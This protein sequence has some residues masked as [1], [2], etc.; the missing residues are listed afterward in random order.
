MRLFRPL[1][2]LHGLD[3][4]QLRLSPTTYDELL[5]FVLE[6]R[7]P[8]P[9]VLVEVVIVVALVTHLLVEGHLVTDDLLSGLVHARFELDV[10]LLQQ[11]CQLPVSVRVLLGDHL[12][13]QLEHV[14]NLLSLEPLLLCHV[15]LQGT[16][17]AELV[18]PGVAMQG[19][20]EL[21]QVALQLVSLARVYTVDDVVKVLL[22]GLIRCRHGV[23][24]LN[25]ECWGLGFLRSLRVSG[26][27]ASAAGDGGWTRS[28]LILLGLGH[29]EQVQHFA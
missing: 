11:L 6:Y 2:L 27:A 24:D 1:D 14:L 10:V 22:L 21:G 3:L 26:R 23:Q 12:P 13:L 25:Q 15:A 18:E 16:L 4:S 8:V 17:E 29:C 19:V 5:R 20:R 28:W 9:L 7:T